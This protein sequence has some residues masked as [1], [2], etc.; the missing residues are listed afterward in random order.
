MRARS[1]LEA[2][3]P[4][5]LRP[6]FRQ[7]PEDQRKALADAIAADPAQVAVVHGPRV[8][9]EIVSDIAT[10]KTYEAF[11]RF[12]AA[13]HE[14]EINGDQPGFTLEAARKAY[15]DAERM[16][17]ANRDAVLTALKTPLRQVVAGDMKALQTPDEHRTARLKDEIT[18]SAQM[19]ADT[20]RAYLEKQTPSPELRVAID[21]ARRQLTA[22]ADPNLPAGVGQVLGAADAALIPSEVREA[23]QMLAELD[24]IEPAYEMDL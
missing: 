14:I 21:G 13:R 5:H 16:A 17:A 24:S 23:E 12:K 3:I 8:L 7:L 15:N 9:G 6:K 22:S 20:L 11:R 18:L 4:R 2:W 10:A 19:G 1:P